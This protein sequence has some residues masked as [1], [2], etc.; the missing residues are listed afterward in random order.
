M[1]AINCRG[2]IYY[3]NDYADDA[4]VDDDVTVDNNTSHYNYQPL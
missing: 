4:D 1:A 3:G 2:A